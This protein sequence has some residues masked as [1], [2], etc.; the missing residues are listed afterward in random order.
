MFGVPLGLV[1]GRAYAQ[2]SAQILNADISATPFPVWV[3]GAVFV[4]GILLPLLFALGPVYRGSRITVQQ[5]LAGDA[6]TRLFGA[7]RFDRW[8]LGVRGLPRPLMLSMRST[9]LRR[10]RLA[11]T[12]GMLAMG[13]GAF[14]SA[15]N[16]S[17]AWTRELVGDFGRRHYDLSVALAAPTPIARLEE[18]LAARP[19]VERAEYWAEAAPYLIG[20]TGVAGSTV[21]MIGPD[22]GSRLLDL[23]L[24]AGRW[25]RADDSTAVVINR[26]VAVRNPKLA[27]GDQV[28]LRF[29]GR[30]VAYPIVGV[31]KELTPMPAV[32]AP[33]S[34]VL[35]LTQR[36]DALARSIRIATRG[37]DD[38]A[39]LAAAKGLEQM[40]QANGIE[41]RGMQRLL[42]A[43]QGILDH[44]VII[45]T[46][47]TMASVIVVIVGALGLTSTLTLNV[48][49]RTREI[50][51]LSAIGATPTT[52]SRHVWFEGVAIGVLS[53]A[54]ACGVAA[55]ISAVL[56]AVVGDIF[57]KAP[58]DFY[59]S[60]S[61]AA[62][63][64]AIVVVVGSASSFY[65]AWRAARLTVRQALSEV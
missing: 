47:L 33:R 14:M 17:G 15:L 46:V 41:V 20:P 11:L 38:A 57:F 19:E 34:A 54:L 16:V 25:L 43:R 6:G 18:L 56:E 22:A 30:T 3:V 29:E 52:I 10:G 1:V 59:L 62:A 13:G 35:A 63:W 64:L 39:Q 12:V 32:Y 40:F 4:V 55:P 36:S 58:L 48:V 51:V 50:G 21:A 9:L 28:A 42:D 2:F 61:A 44:L 65:P 53:W 23:P 49:Q 27:V 45:F 37:H 7:R 5:A 24:L 60:W 31:V 8:L 26:G